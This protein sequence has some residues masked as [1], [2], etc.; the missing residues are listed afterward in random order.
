[1][2]V[3][4]KEHLK[5]SVIYSA[6]AAVPSLLQVLVQPLTEGNSRLNA[7]DFA[8]IGIAEMI[9]SLAFTVVL[10]S[11]G[12]AVS[13]FYYDYTDDRKGY[14]RMVSSVY[15]SMLVRGVLLLGV[16]FVF[17][18]YIGNLFEQV[19]LKDFTRYGFA[20][21]V[22]GI[23]RAINITAATLYRN[24][25]RVSAFVIVNISMALLR[26]GFQLVGLFFFDMSFLGY[27]YGSA[28][29]GSLVTLGILVYSYRK[30]GFHYD[31]G[32][33]KSMFQFAA[34][35]FQYGLLVWG[36]TFA[37]K[38]F[39]ERFPSELGIYFTAA[40]F[41][42]GM[43]IIL[44]GLQG[45]TQPEIFRYMKEGIKAREE[46]IKSL[47][48]MLMAQTQALI[49]ITIIPVMLFLYL[50]YETDVRLAYSFISIIYIRY[51]PRTQYIIFSFVLYYEKKTRFF[52]Y[53]NLVTLAV[54]MLL[55]FLLI[56]HLLIY[57]A[58][59]AV[60]VS[61]LIQVAGTYIYAQRV[62]PISWN[63]SKMLYSPL[64]CVVLVIITEL[65]KDKLGVSP[66]IPAVFS[67][68]IMLFALV[69]LYRREVR[70]VV[71]KYFRFRLNTD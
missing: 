9:T 31:R 51:L 10:F 32:L 69:F 27:V 24:E 23:N 56:P 6:V 60:L 66:F 26:T 14:N 38:Y 57:G 18:N 22:I 28:I 15:S 55:N 19:E 2:K 71:N 41:A 11:M 43:Q 49:A 12:N 35:L 44:Q 13:R 1:M 64:I 61:D 29:G 21:I 30:S 52:F 67:V 3:N 40:N 39:M 8:H 34:P 33:L 54:N 20:S 25:K 65:I 58:I 5:L 17:R 16:A 62:A 53:L 70:G 46:E 42:L 7:T 63:L 68:V 48:N 4:V 50:F 59:I 37:D 36:L 45:A 47:S